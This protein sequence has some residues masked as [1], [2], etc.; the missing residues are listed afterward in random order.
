MKA[1]QYRVPTA[2]VTDQTQAPRVTPYEKP[3]R[4]PTSQVFL[5]Q[6][7]S[8][9]QEFSI[10]NQPYSLTCSQNGLFFLANRGKSDQGFA[11]CN[12][13]GRDLSDKAHTHTGTSPIAHTRP[14]DG[15]P[16]TGR[17]TR[18]HLG[19]EFR[20]DLLKIQFSNIPNEYLLFKPVI[21]IADG[22]EIA[23]QLE[24]TTTN[25]G[26]WRSL[27]YALLAAA[28]QIIDVPR[29]ELDGLFQPVQNSNGIAEIVIYDNVP[30]GAGYAQQIAAKF[31]EV[32]QRAYELVNSC[33][34]GTSCYDCLRTYSNQMFHAELNRHVVANFLQPLLEQIEPDDILRDFAPDSHRIP[35]NKVNTE[36][37]SFCRLAMSGILYLPKFDES[38]TS[39]NWQKHL[40]EATDSI[41]SG[42]N[43]LELILHEI[44]K[45]N[46]DEHRFLRKRLY[47]WIDQGSLKIYQ[48]DLEIQPELYLQMRSQHPIALRLHSDIEPLWLQ[49]RSDRGCETVRQRLEDLKLRSR[50]VSSLELDDPNI[51]IINP[52]RTW[53]NLTLTELR[54]RLG[55]TAILE[56]QSVQ[57]IYYSDRYLQPEAAEILVD[58][59]QGDWLKA[60]TQISVRILELSEQSSNRRAEIQAAL[61]SINGNVT[62][63]SRR[64]PNHIDHGR[65]LEIH[66]VDGSNCKLLFDRGLD[67]LRKSQDQKYEIRESSYVVLIQS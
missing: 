38:I 24:A 40:Q 5:S 22:N 32:L 39:I 26:F 58:L 36:F 21:H 62:Q 10:P 30:G 65:S 63:Q 37:L 27:L 31:G 19:H 67:F 49:T 66:K 4:Q 47:Q 25:Q 1:K 3:M 18:I 57:R 44:P 13:C 16:C 20:S 50:L 33:D 28:A 41:K 61:Q 7:G 2:F 35:L 59:L 46:S 52:D 8:N 45:P 55:L 11:I 43:P 51:Q 60:N 14:N 29:N 17:Y 34:C 12:F 48:S 54:D 64:D 15:R 56:G 53:K 23:T 9:S 6:D 42:E